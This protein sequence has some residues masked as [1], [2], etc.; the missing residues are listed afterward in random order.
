VEP[1]TELDIGKY[2]RLI[3]TKRV[4]FALTVMLVTSVLVI[5]AYLR[6]KLYE[7]KSIIFIERSLIN[8]MVKNVTISPSFEDRTRVLSV[9]M[10]SRNFIMKVLA[11]LDI[12]VSNRS[13][14]DVESLVRGFQN[15]TEIRVDMNSRNRQDVD[16]FIVSYTGRDPNLASNYVNT[17]IRRYITDNLSMK[18]EEAS[19]ANRF[20]LEQIDLFKKKIART[21]AEIAGI[22][23]NKSVVLNERLVVMQKKLNELLMQYTENHPEVIKVKAE[24][25]QLAAQT[26]LKKGDPGTS[27]G[28]GM[29]ASADVLRGEHSPN[30]EGSLPARD[31]PTGKKS[32]LDLEHE[33]EMNKRIYEELLATLG[34]AEL[35]TQVEVHDKA[36]A[37]KIVEPAIVP[38]RPMSQ[39]VLKMV[40]IG[41]FGGI[42]AGFGIIIGLDFLDTSLRSVEAVKKLGLPVLAIIPTI[43]TVQE[44][45]RS[46][47][48]DRLLYTSVGVYLTG[49]MAI[50]LIEMM[51]LPYVDNIVQG[52]QAEIKSSLNRIW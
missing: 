31:V 44:A 40:L 5:A 11:D 24:I 32:L 50:V 3:Y 37:F 25:E 34:K 33:R 38:T 4:L 17:L 2:V 27:P 14:E 1:S 52:A 6:P 7:A 48:K 13:A 9:V 12:D 45:A 39:N 16:V 35:T 18:Q 23:K 8:D 22:R 47:I 41:I 42:A 21:E 15:A 10:K 26:K 19:G 28:A 30:A 36:G 51:G 20:L 49:L 46:R 43:Q 29:A